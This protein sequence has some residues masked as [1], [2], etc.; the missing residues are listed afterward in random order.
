MRDALL[1]LADGS[2][3][4]GRALGARGETFGEMVFNTS[5]TGYQEVL[6]DPSYH[7]QIVAMTYPHQGNYGLNDIDNEAPHPWVR[8]FVVR[9]ATSRPSSWRSEESLPAYL[10]RHGVTGIAGIDTRRLTRRLRVHGAMTGG[11]TTDY[12][13]P[14]SFVERVRSAPGIVGRDLV[15]EVTPQQ[16]VDTN[17][18]ELLGSGELAGVRA[19]PDPRVVGARVAAIDLGM[20]RNILR[21]LVATGFTTRVFGASAPVA[22]ILAWAPDGVFVSN[23]PGDPAAVPYVVETLRA[24]LDARIPTFGICLGHQVLG[25]ALGATTY[26]LKFGHRGANHPVKS[27]TSGRVEITTQNHGFAVACGVDPSEDGE[28]WK[29]LA[30]SSPDRWVWPSRYGDVALTHFDLNDGTLEGLRCL[31]VP[32]YSVQYH[33]EAA[34]GPRDSRYLFE[35]F[36]DLVA[37][38]R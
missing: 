14:G 38:G 10:E 30:A 15:R 18:A 29:V 16:P 36:A 20:K 4:R 17:A 37:A 33:P 25:T 6:T 22:D 32:A 31:D 23:G 7:G 19:E 35:S 21:C 8:G 26:K 11:I 28:A 2:V 34:P 12:L 1:A 5:L 9:E 24:L 13:D 27:L 3:F